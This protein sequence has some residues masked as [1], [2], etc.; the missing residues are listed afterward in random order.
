MQTFV[1]EYKYT[2]AVISEVM[3]A[4]WGR[5]LRLSY[6]AAGVCALLAVALLLMDS[7]WEALALLLMCVLT[8]AVF[9]GKEKQA[10][11][12][13]LERLEVNYKNAI[14]TFHIEI[15]DDIRITADQLEKRVSFSDTKKVVE[16]KNLIVV[17]T[18]GNMTVALDKNGFLSGNAKECMD[19]LK[20]H[21]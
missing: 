2:E 6:I 18:K 9:K 15:G 8:I 3:K 1:N 20:K 4:W 5:S 11:K 13:E 10:A 21:I 12:L 14:P 16:T 7:G 19:Y 17:F